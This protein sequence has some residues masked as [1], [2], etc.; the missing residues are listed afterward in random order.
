MGFTFGIFPG[1][2]ENLT[3]LFLF[4]ILLIQWSEALVLTGSSSGEYSSP[5]IKGYFLNNFRSQFLITKATSALVGHLLLTALLVSRA[6]SSHH[7]PLTNLY[8]SLL[9]LCWALSLIAL[10][11]EKQADKL[12]EGGFREDSTLNLP[13]GLILSPVILLIYLFANFTLPAEMLK[14]SPLVPALQSNWLLMHVSVMIL[15]YGAL[16]AGS[17]LAVAYLVVKSENRNKAL[18]LDQLSYRVLGIGFPLLTLGIISGAIWANQAWGSF[19]SWDPKETWAL[20]TW[21]V[22]ASYLHLRMNQGWQ[23][24][25]PAYLALFGF[26]VVWICYLGVNIFGSGLHSYG[27]L[28]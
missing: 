24:D 9:F 8:E 22:F 23:G 20:I 7:F 10:A 15:A 27:F 14:I 2:V 12:T 25:K 6:I 28:S 11:L 16:L 3:S 5:Q 17:L 19:W 26:F 18:F 21:F 4:F 1:F 13:L